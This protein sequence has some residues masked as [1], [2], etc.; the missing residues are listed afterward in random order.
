M[1]TR[2]A[3]E[4]FVD[5]DGM[6]HD[7]E[8]NSWF[9]GEQHAGTYPGTGRLPFPLSGGGGGWRSRPVNSAQL[10]AL[11]AL[12]AKKPGDFVQSVTSQ[13]AR[14]FKLSDRQI[15]VVVR[16]LRTNGLTEE[17]KHFDRDAYAKIKS[18]VQPIGRSPQLDA[19][20]NLLR[21]KPDSFVQSLRDQ[22]AKG[23]SLSEAQLKAL[24][25]ILYRNVMR[26]EAE[27]FRQAAVKTRIN[28]WG[29]EYVYRD[30]GK[31]V[32]LLVNHRDYGWCVCSGT[33]GNESYMPLNLPTGATVEDARKEVSRY[34][35]RRMAAR[36]ACLYAGGSRSQS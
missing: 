16:M 29:I 9:V 27:L 31:E 18:P 22:I 15:E 25:A 12:S 24:R 5:D 30:D 35:F 7:D 3:F 33:V 26:S 4:V 28:R 1:I 32:G 17:I 21:R 20:D 14:G 34:D 23:R 2:R 8:G 10:K 13:V 36:I 11:E 6:A 19:L